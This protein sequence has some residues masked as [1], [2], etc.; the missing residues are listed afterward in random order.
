MKTLIV[1]LLFGIGIA[2]SSGALA[3]FFIQHAFNLAVVLIVWG[4]RLRVRDLES[5]QAFRYQT[6]GDL[7]DTYKLS[8]YLA[9]ERLAKRALAYN[10]AL[11]RM[12]FQKQATRLYLENRR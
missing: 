3:P 10:R 7:A 2:V 9:Q 12:P 4:L 8:Y 11:S 1:L 5:L 6:D